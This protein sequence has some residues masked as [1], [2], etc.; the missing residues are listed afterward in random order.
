MNTLSKVR[1]NRVY[2]RV[3]IDSKPPLAPVV[4]QPIT[5]QP[6][7]SSCSFP[8]Q[9]MATMIGQK[10]VG[11][12]AYEQFVLTR[13]KSEPLRSVPKLAVAPETCFWKNRKLE[14]HRQAAM[15]VGAAGVGF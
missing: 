5:M 7:R 8:V 6:P 2:G 9:S 3:S 13:C 15:G 10:L 11:S 14:P 1:H 4:Q 12:A